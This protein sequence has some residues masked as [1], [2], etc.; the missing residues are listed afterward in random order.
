M[1]HTVVIENAP[2]NFAAYVHHLPGGV[3]TGINRED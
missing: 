1:K 2:N 3:A